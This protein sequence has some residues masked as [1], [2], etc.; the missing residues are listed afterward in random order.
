MY[1]DVLTLSTVSDRHTQN[2]SYSDNNNNSNDSNSSSCSGAGAV[3]AVG[4]S[5][6]GG[7]SSSSSDDDG[8]DDDDSQ[9]NDTEKRNSNIFFSVCATICPQLVRSCGNDAMRERVTRSS[10]VRPRGEM[11]QV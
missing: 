2:S 8:D 9:N 1:L 7:G 6:V 10:S 4:G 3:V 11:S 5:G